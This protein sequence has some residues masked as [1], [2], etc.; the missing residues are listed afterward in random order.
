MKNNESH[1]TCFACNN[2]KPEVEIGDKFIDSYDDK[3]VCK[4][5]ND[6]KGTEDLENILNNRKVCL[7]EDELGKIVADCLFEKKIYQDILDEFEKLNIHEIDGTPIN[8]RSDT[9][10]KLILKVHDWQRSNIEW[11]LKSDE[12]LMNK[13]SL[14]QTLE[15]FVHTSQELYHELF[16]WY[17]DSFGNG[18]EWVM[19]DDESDRY[20]DWINSDRKFEEPFR[21]EAPARQC[22]DYPSIGKVGIASFIQSPHIEAGTS[23]E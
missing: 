3:Y 19:P 8:D 16:R 7:N 20:I 2:N 10:L 12:G 15:A 5:C 9:L 1:F 18:P 6:T 23:W 22:G 11:I 17:V 13:G 14:D 21:W 4:C